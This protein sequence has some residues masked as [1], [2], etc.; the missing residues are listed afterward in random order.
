M[1]M[2]SEEYHQLLSNDMMLLAGCNNADIGCGGCEWRDT[3][4]GD[5]HA[6]Q[7]LYSV[8]L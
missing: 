1:I 7:A 8:M 4:M 6:V 3:D 5:W 2:M